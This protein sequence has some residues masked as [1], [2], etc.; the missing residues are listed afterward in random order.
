MRIRRAKKKIDDTS[1]MDN[2]NAERADMEAQ[3]SAGKF[4]VRL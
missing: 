2:F 3:T 4:N 1:E